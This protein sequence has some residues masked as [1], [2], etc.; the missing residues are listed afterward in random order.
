MKVQD[1]LEVT[2]IQAHLYSGQLPWPQSAVARLR[3]G[4]SLLDKQGQ[5]QGSGSG[6][7]LPKV[8]AYL[9][10]NWWP[11]P[12]KEFG[13]RGIYICLGSGFFLFPDPAY[14]NVSPED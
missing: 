1:T 5:G 7:N 11:M 13:C 3:L 2:E 10:D 9:I 8:G 14:K 12:T 4:Q 6:K